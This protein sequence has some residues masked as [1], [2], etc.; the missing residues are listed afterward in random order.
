MSLLAAAL[1]ALL[2]IG[3]ALCLYLTTPHQ[4]LLAAPLSTRAAPIIGWLCL[5][6]ALAIL[7]GVMGPGTAVFTWTIGLMMVWTIPPV[8][9][10]WLRYRTGTRS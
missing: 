2:L 5:A 10:G 9:V 6:A 4:R 1:A 7:L 8:V 3:G